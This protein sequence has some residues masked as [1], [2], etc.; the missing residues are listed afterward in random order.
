MKAAHSSTLGAI[1]HMSHFW[2][3]LRKLNKKSELAGE[4]P[5]ATVRYAS[6][7]ALSEVGEELGGTAWSRE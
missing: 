6:V 4:L 2:K 3:V 7:E 5:A 1:T